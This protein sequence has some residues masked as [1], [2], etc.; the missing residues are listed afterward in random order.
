VRRLSYVCWGALFGFLLS[1]SGATSFAR[2]HAMFL[3]EEFHMFGLIGTAIPVALLGF[4]AIRRLKARGA[5]PAATRLPERRFFP[6][7]VPGAVLFGIGWGL[8][9]TCPGPAIVQVGEGRFVAVFTVGG[10][11]LGNW[12]YRLVHQKWFRWRMEVCG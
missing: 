7:L 1:R 8:A 11:L 3:F 4:L 2:L 10:I 6:G 5:L 12:L 9:G